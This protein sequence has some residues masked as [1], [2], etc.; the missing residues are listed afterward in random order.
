MAHQRISIIEEIC[1]NHCTD[2]Q[3][4]IPCKLDTLKRW[5]KSLMNLLEE[6][7]DEDVE[8]VYK[9]FNNGI[10]FLPAY[11]EVGEDGTQRFFINISYPKEEQ[12]KA[13]LHELIHQIPK[14]EQQETPLEEYR[15]NEDVVERIAEDL[16]ELGFADKIINSK[17]FKRLIPQEQ[18]ILDIKKEEQAS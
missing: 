12:D 9:K 3:I 4:H 6:L 13:L 2:T 11:E 16:Y 17:Y 7:S 18:V 1:N 15:L 10:K 5:G 8:I 14:R